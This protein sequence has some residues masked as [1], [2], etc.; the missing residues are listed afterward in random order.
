MYVAKARWL[1]AMMLLL[2][3]WS[4]TLAFGIDVNFE[5]IALILLKEGSG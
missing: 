3:D 5:P 4:L 2:I 1:I